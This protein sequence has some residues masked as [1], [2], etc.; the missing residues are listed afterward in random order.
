MYTYDKDLLAVV[1]KL[2]HLEFMDT[3][4]AVWYWA[5]SLG[6]LRVVSRAISLHRF[7]ISICV[8][9][10]AQT[11]LDIIW[12]CN[13]SMS[14][15]LDEKVIARKT[16][17]GKPASNREFAKAVSDYML[18]DATR[19][20]EPQTP[21][22]IM[23]K[24]GYKDL[25]TIRQF[26]DLAI[27]LGFLEI[28][29]YGKP[30][31]PDRSKLLASFRRFDAQHDFTNDALVSRWREDLLTRKKGK[32]IDSWAHYL[33]T[34][35]A[36]C[37]TLKI[38]PEQFI[39]GRNILEVLE[40][41]RTYMKAFMKLYSEH[42][43]DIQYTKNWS[44]DNIDLEH[45][46]YSYSKSV[47]DFMRFYGYGYAKGE[48]GVMSQNISSFHGKYSGVR[49]SDEQITV[50]KKFIKDTVGID[51]DLFRVFTFG[52]QTCARKGAILGASTNYTTHTSKKTGNTTYIME[53][54]ESK[55]KH[56]KQGIR[57][58][59]VR[60]VELQQSIDVL[61]KRGG[62][63]L[64]ED[65]KS[66]NATYAKLTEQLKEV[67]VKMGIASINPR[68]RE[69]PE[70]GYPLEHA[71]HTLRHLGA[72]FLL[73]KKKY[74]Y[75]L[76]AVI[77]DWKTIDELKDSYGEMPPEIVLELMEDDDFSGDVQL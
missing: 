22:E 15:V 26:K 39:V 18:G 68:I 33:R 73:R 62:L 23:K 10:I 27:A 42:K 34:F 53:V 37:N 76:V 40:Q 13:H 21:T 57:T 56:I 44:L 24:L 54:Y 77:G 3:L 67:Y 19:G 70:T 29:E 31:L 38:N 25:K 55:T 30:K 2:Q 20:I 75:G 46:A 74:H 48:T 43:A 51:S 64:V 11:T 49:A 8:L 12:D 50:G 69:R 59:L 52:I 72:H 5:Y 41:G 17:N 6:I 14:T 7:S 4:E 36:V 61:K 1:T 35:E 71:F 63:Y 60:D 66:M 32:P 65:R 9:Q 28:D 16:L 47:R 58:K 45:I